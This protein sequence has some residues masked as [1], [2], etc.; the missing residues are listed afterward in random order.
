MNAHRARRQEAT[1][2]TISASEIGEYA[3]CSR[4]WW[5]RHVVKLPVPEGQGR[6]RLNAGTQAHRQHGAWVASSARLR[7][8]GIALAMCG[9]GV[10]ILAFLITR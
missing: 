8:A 3:Y 6:S 9:V 10:L 2:P 7:M 4:A 5:Y 1:S